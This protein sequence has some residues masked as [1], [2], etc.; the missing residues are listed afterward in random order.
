MS[1][2]ANAKVSPLWN[3]AKRGLTGVITGA[4]VSLTVIT[5]LAVAVLPQ[6]S[7]AVQVRT[8]FFLLLH[9]ESVVV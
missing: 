9:V 6:A 8:T 2:Q 5:W 4:I 1:S 3:P 7:V